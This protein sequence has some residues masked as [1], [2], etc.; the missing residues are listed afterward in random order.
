MT[1]RDDVAHNLSTI[2][3]ITAEAKAL[4][5]DL[6]AFPEMAPFFSHDRA[7][8]EAFVTP[9]QGNGTVAALSKIAAKHA[10][11]LWIGSLATRNTDGRIV[12]RTL[13]FDRSGALVSYYDKIHLFDVDLGEGE[14]YGE[15]RTYAAGDQAVVCDIAGARLGL[16][17]CYDLRFP[18]L[19]RHLAHAGADIIGVPAAFTR[20]TG[21]AHWEVMLRA[22]A[23]ETGAFVIAPAQC[24]DHGNGRKTWGHSMIIDPWGNIIAAAGDEPT[25]LHA[26]ID[27]T[28]VDHARKKMP[29]WNTPSSFMPAKAAIAPALKAAGE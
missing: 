8:L 21:K 27:L 29:A 23:I 9:F 5:A 20:P 17:I 22:R 12:N 14:R 13:V 10:I 11:N 15:S 16:T 1:S 3:Q 26:E 28:A 4:D 7:A 24:G 6:V 18:S 2:D 19:Y 25:H